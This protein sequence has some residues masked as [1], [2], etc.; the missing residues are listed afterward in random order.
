MPAVHTERS[1]AFLEQIARIDPA[2]T[3]VVLWDGAGFHP[4]DEAGDVPVNVRLIRLPPCSP[5]LN[6]AQKAGAR[7]RRALANRLPKNLAELDQWAT[8]V[9]RPLWEDPAEVRSLIGRRWLPI[10]VNVSSKLE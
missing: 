8:E 3:H 7:L 2:S 4:R 5:E 6:P 9:L 10:Q 1:L